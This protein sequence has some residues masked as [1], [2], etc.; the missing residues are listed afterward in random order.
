MDTSH[1]PRALARLTWDQRNALEDIAIAWSIEG[2]DL[3]EADL[4]AMAG[5]MLGEI[6]RSELVARMTAP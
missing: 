5:L 1:P 3:D 6:S 4:E 2:E